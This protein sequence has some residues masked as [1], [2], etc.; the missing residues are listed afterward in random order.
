[1]NENLHH[2]LLHAGEGIIK[3]QAFEQQQADGQ[4]LTAPHVVT[5]YFEAPGALTYGLGRV[6]G[7]LQAFNPQPVTIGFCNIANLPLMKVSFSADTFC[8]IVLCCVLCC[9]VLWCC[10]PDYAVL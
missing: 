2:L 8:C 4:S 10:N 5:G 3:E 6:A 1:M 9:A 7:A